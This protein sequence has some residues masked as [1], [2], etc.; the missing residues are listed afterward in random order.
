MGELHPRTYRTQ[1][2]SRLL[3]HQ[4][5]PW[6]HP[7]GTACP[8]SHRN[9]APPRALIK[10]LVVSSFKDTDPL[11]NLLTQ[12]I[13]GMRHLWQGKIEVRFRKVDTG[14]QFVEAIND[15]GGTILIFD[16]HGVAN[17]V[18]FVGALRIG[19]EN[20]D[21]WSLRRRIRIPPIV[22]LS[23]CDT[24]GIGS[25]SHATVGNGFLAIGV[26][27]VLAT[28]L[29]VGG[30]A[31][32][33]FIARLLHRL[34]NFIPAVLRERQT[35]LNWS[36]VISGMLRMVLASKLAD[37]LVGPSGDVRND[38]LE[39]VNYSINTD[40]PDWFDLILEQLV[41]TK[42]WIREYAEARAADVIAGSESIRYVQLGNPKTILID[43]GSIRQRFIPNEEEI[44]RA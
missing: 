35:T 1:F 43:D 15:F 4:Q 12:S 22:V 36:E 37:A 11:K 9:L 7:N 28:M 16:G 33:A 34:A 27:T 24:H 40:Q 29:P 42:G 39:R 20:L 18:S 32:G 3:A 6:Q 19:P 8:S 13:M 17:D 23:A 2:R 38:L 5:H 44:L 31:S 25:S 26:R 30:A 14:D 41:A 21:V 10:I